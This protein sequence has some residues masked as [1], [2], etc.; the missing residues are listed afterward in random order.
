MESGVTWLLWLCG[1]WGLWKFASG[2]PGPYVLC[3]SL[4]SHFRIP[5][6]FGQVPPLLDVLMTYVVGHSTFYACCF[7]G[8]FFFTSHWRPCWLLSSVPRASGEAAKLR[9][10]RGFVATADLIRR[11]ALQVPAAFFLHS[12]FEASCALLSLRRRRAL[13]QLESEWAPTK[14]PRPA[15]P[16]LTLLHPYLYFFFKEVPGKGPQGPIRLEQIRPSSLEAPID[17]WWPGVPAPTKGYPVLFLI[18]GGAWR[19]GHRRCSPQAPL[20]QALA[21]AGFLI[22]SCEYRRRRGAQWPVQLE[23]CKAALEWL[24]KDGATLGA[25]L[26]DVS[27]AGASA[28]G[29]LAALLLATPLQSPSLARGASAIRF[30]AVLLCYPAL[31]PADRSGATVKSPFSCSLLGVRRGM[32]FLAWFFEVFVLWCDRQLWV[33]A[34]PLE[35]LKAASE[36]LAGAWPPTL[37]IHGELDGVVPVEHSRQFLT[38]L[39]A[40]AGAPKG[41]EEWRSKDQLFIVPLSRHAFEIATGDLTAA[42]FDAAITWLDLGTTYSCVGVWK[43]DGVEIIANDQGN[44]T[45]PSYVAFTDTERLIGDAAKNQVFDAKRLIGRKFQDPIVQSDIKLWPFKCVA[46]PSDKPLIVVQVEGEDSFKEG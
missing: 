15:Q 1:W 29:H 36:E 14:Q 44:R 12:F 21:A 10:V 43:N 17:V 28:G 24:E 2:E 34:E 31:D 40:R 41:G 9:I 46:G 32:S 16:W 6:P 8:V 4:A 18:H 37:I 35:A 27:I 22:V 7:S 13:S 3:L 23:D 42:S 19:G 30:R 26:S 25:D 5:P 11:V 39:A 38:Q 33:S 45:T 20:L